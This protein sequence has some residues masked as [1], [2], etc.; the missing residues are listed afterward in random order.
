MAPALVRAILCVPSL[1]MPPKG[2]AGVVPVLS[3]RSAFA[4][5]EGKHLDEYIDMAAV[6]EVQSPQ[7]FSRKLLEAAYAARDKSAVL[8]DDAEVVMAGGGKIQTIPG[9]R[10]NQ[11]IDSDEA[12]KIAADLIAR[13]P[14]PKPKTPLTPFDEAQW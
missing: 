2:L 13:M 7:I 5:M 12:L 8:M 10:F 14:K 11:R 6:S 9:T 4:G 3:S 1:M